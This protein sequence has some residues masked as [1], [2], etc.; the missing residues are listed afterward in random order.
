MASQVLDLSVVKDDLDIERVQ[1]LRAGEITIERK[2]S[3]VTN[4]D[5]ARE[6]S[7]LRRI[8]T[9]LMPLL[10]TSYMLQFMD[11]VSLGNASIMGLL[12]DLHLVGQDYSWVSGVFYFGYLAASYP[13]SFILVR[14]PL[15]K[16]LAIAMF[17]WGIILLCHAA[18]SSFAGIMVTRT[19]LGVFESVVSP[20]FTLITSIW[21][22]P[23]EHA[24]RHGFWYAGNSMGAC[25]GTL[26]AFGCAHIH[27]KGGLAAWRYLFI[28]LGALTVVWGA[29]LSWRLPDEPLKAKFLNELDRQVA[30][31]RA[32]SKTKTTKTNKWVYA[33]FI[34]TLRDPKTWFLFLLEGTS[35]L[36]NG[37]VTNFTSIILSS[38]GFSTLTTLLLNMPVYG[39]QFISIMV[40]SF[41]ARR[42]R[43]SRIIIIICGSLIALFGAIIIMKLP[44]SNKGGRFVGLM[45]LMASTNGFS[46]T[47][48]LISSNVGGFTKRSTTNAIFFI[49][50]CAGNIAGP[51]L[52]KAKEKP[53]YTTAFTSIMAV[54][55]FDIVLLFLFRCYLDWM[56][57]KRDREQGIHIDPE[58]RG[59]DDVDE[60]RIH[61]STEGEDLTDWQNQRFRYVL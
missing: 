1:S 14:Y 35:T 37:I 50:Y 13:V 59:V 55:A 42:F 27:H 31:N 36:T 2:A 33:Q 16:S 8:D 22:K 61:P 19:L 25:I 20:G 28:I 5:A 7:V 43:R 54:S 23:S 45:M 58:I 44:Y 26:I 39:F 17:I 3:P 30:H 34:E 41:L 52:Y 6:L 4:V 32:Q 38:F 51:Q 9:F 24:L 12:P 60:S 10:V 21:Y 47:L 29:V 18:T 15:G 49:A 57:K 53:K 40:S 11:K 46:L 48:S 56:N